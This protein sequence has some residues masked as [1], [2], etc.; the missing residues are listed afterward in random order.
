MKIANVRDFRNKALTYLKENESV[1]I[2]RHGKI[3]GVLYPIKDTDTLPEDMR[4]EFLKLMAPTREQ[5][6]E[7]RRLLFDGL[8]KALRIKGKPTMT[9]EEIRNAWTY[10]GKLSDELITEREKR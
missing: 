5:Q 1:L 10:R 7:Q 8:K 4:K 9:I 6:D 2:T 3:T